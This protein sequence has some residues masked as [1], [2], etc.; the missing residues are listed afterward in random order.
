M[1]FGMETEGYSIEK[2]VVQRTGFKGPLAYSDHILMHSNP[3]TSE[4]TP[5]SMDWQLH[6]CRLNFRSRQ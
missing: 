1:R 5:V 6:K 3:F 2:T 4:G